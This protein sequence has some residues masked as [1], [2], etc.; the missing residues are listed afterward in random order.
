MEKRE[1]LRQPPSDVRAKIVCWDRDTVDRVIPFLRERKLSSFRD[2]GFLDLP[3]IQIT[4]GWYTDGWMGPQ[5]QVEINVP[6]ATHFQFNFWTPPELGDSSMTIVMNGNTELIIPL[7]PSVKSFATFEVPAGHSK[8]TFT[9]SNSFVP[10]IL[11]TNLDARSLSLIGS[12]HRQVLTQ[13]YPK[14]EAVH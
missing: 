8:L 1:A 10:K 12:L 13:V 7:K 3:V 14:V 6:E 9:A 2:P 4:A 11:G 5:V